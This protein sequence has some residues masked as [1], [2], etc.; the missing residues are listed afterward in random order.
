M[1]KFVS[2]GGKKEQVVYVGAIAGPGKKEIFVWSESL[3]R[4]YM[5]HLA[6]RICLECLFGY[7]FWSICA[8]FNGYTNYHT[9]EDS[10]VVTVGVRS[11]YSR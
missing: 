1:R 4:S 8:R 5:I 2:M 10:E 7:V 3:K 6:L 11:S 9:P